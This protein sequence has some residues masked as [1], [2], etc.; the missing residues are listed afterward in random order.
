MLVAAGPQPREVA[1]VDQRRVAVQ[2]PRLAL[3]L[4]RER[5]A[6]ELTPPRGAGG[7]EAPTRSDSRRRLAIE[8][9]AARH[10]DVAELLWEA[11]DPATRHGEVLVDPDEGAGR[12]RFA[13][14]HAAD[15]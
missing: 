14:E 4:E 12:H 6:G 3:V 13:V 11:L 7:P 10:P 15:H 2:R 9:E 1:Y 8:L 5:R